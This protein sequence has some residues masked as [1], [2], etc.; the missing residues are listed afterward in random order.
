MTRL[1]IAGPHRYPD[2]ARLWH[3]FLLRQMLPALE[4]RRV[5]VDLNIFCDANAGDFLPHLFPGVRLTRSGREARD[6]MEFYDAT[7]N[8]PSD[9]ILFLDADTF[10][11]D[12]EWACSYLKAFDDPRV[13]AVSL[14]PRKGAPAIF[15]L[16]CRTESY[17]ALRP[18]VFACRYEF[19]ENWPGGVNLQ[20]GDFAARELLRSAK[21][22]VNVG[23]DESSRHT[24]NFRGTT[25]I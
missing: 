24:V 1:L 25:G 4:R 16:L 2:L 18:P 11:L 17:R 23:A 6:F 22:I 13:A 15:A 12:G 7:L 9:F 10:L 5:V 19:P 20:P 8:A 21:V 3:R 14:V